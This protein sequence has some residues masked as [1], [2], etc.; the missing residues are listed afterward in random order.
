MKY[1]VSADIHGFYDIWMQELNNKG[2]DINNPEHKI[3]VCGD[4]FDRGNQP[5]EIIKFILEHKDK[6]ILI[7][8]NHEDLMEQMIARNKNDYGDIRNGTAQTIVD[9]YEQ[10][11]ITEF[12]LSKISKETGLD[13][14]LSMCIDYFETEN[15][16]LCG[17]RGWFT[18]RSMQTASQNVD[19]SKIIN[20][21]IIR[22]KMS[23]EAAKTL[24]NQSNKEILAFLHFPPVWSDF[25]CD[26]IINLLSEYGIKRCYFGH[27]H[28]VYTVPST[29]VDS[30]ISFCM[31]SADFL[32]FIP[33]I[34]P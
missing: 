26:E 4:L 32:D 11:L 22:L 19:Y 7:K 14:V 29:F 10:W 6:V 17:S 28:G 34:I 3:I 20:R 21:E 33:Q 23:L 16:I 27:I 9:L 12:D 31:I 5:K 25:R 13:E 1:F 18:D 24:K 8:G 15:Y 30:G 2:F